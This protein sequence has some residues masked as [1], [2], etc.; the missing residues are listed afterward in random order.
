M[1]GQSLQTAGWDRYKQLAGIATNSGLDAAG[2]TLGRSPTMGKRTR[3]AH[4]DPQRRNCRP[5]CPTF[6]VMESFLSTSQAAKRLHVSAETLRRWDR[7][8][9]V[10]PGVYE[11]TSGRHRRWRADRIDE[12]RV[13]IGQ[14]RTAAAPAGVSAGAIDV[15]IEQ[16]LDG[17]ARDAQTEPLLRREARFVVVFGTL[18][19]LLALPLAISLAR[20]CH[21]YI[22]DIARRNE[23]VSPMAWTHAMSWVMRAA[24][25]F[26]YT[27]LAGAALSLAAAMV[28]AVRKRPGS[29]LWASRYAVLLAAGAMS[30]LVTLIVASIAP[31]PGHTGTAQ[32]GAAVIELVM[33]AALVEATRSILTMMLRSATP[34]SAHLVWHAQIALG[35]DAPAPASAPTESKS[36][37]MK[38][39]QQLVRAQ[40]SSSGS[41]DD[42]PAAEMIEQ[43]GAGEVGGSAA[44]SVMRWRTEL[45]FTMIS[46]ASA[47]TQ[48]HLI[49]GSPLS[50]GAR[51]AISAAIS[52]VI[53][54]CLAWLLRRYGS[55]CQAF[56]YV[57]G[58]SI[59]SLLSLVV[60]LVH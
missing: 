43:T 33:L 16:H 7:R 29:A 9:L 46:S 52:L 14:G 6:Q 30:M 4:H 55:A 17:L 24:L 58:A 12:L 5:P 28:L 54:A 56:G 19:A 15:M 8:G 48:L 32:I 22:E 36:L 60:V 13:L 2:H 31:P 51:I 38:I 57:S 35:Q 50:H 59:V 40:T 42:D 21:A 3:D 34:L 37:A 39:G 41:G 23:S 47:F 20:Y 18:L 25:A 45:A 26:D 27:L 49:F 53:L 1:S 11:Q 44:K 10:A